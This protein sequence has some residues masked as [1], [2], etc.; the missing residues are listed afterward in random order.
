MI[1]DP[2]PPPPSGGC[3]TTVSS[4]A[5]AQS[6]VQA[7]KAGDTV[8]I[9]AGT[10]A[11]TLSLSGSKTA[12]GVTVRSANPGAAKLTAVNV[13][14]AGYTIA[15]F[16]IDPTSNGITLQ[17][18]SS[19]VRIEHN[20]LH[21]GPYLIEFAST[22]CTVPGAPRWS[23]CTAGAPISDV[24]IVGNRFARPSENAMRVNNFRNVTVEENEITG[25]IE[26]GSHVDGLQTIFGGDG[27]VYRRNYH[28]D[29]Q[30]QQFFIKDGQ[31]RNVVLEDNLFVRNTA[32]PQGALNT[33]SW[34]NVI[35]MTARRNTVW[36]A[37]PGMVIGNWGGLGSANVVE[38]NVIQHFSIDPGNGTE[39]Q[40]AALVTE[41]RNTFGG[42]SYPGPGG[43]YTAGNG[44]WVPNR[45]SST[46]QILASPPFVA[47]AS[48][49]YRLAGSHPAAGAR[50]V[51]WKP[52]DYRYGP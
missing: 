9:A 15:G 32:S 34:T 45:M 22:D 10:Y 48:D 51:S 25:V 36:A 50:G 19:R 35:G 27:L 41:R 5:A 40:L 8:C 4:L 33:V 14:G 13:N 7:A 31:A 24:Q 21:D 16:D 38:D 42:T 46:S 6:S 2:P 52:S 12:P 18:G 28:H 29:N 20:Y 49:D 11:G 1:V 47:P 37:R 3:S 30:A 26:S 17:P 23:G 39:A 44:N 43:T